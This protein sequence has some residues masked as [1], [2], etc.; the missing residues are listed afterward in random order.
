[1]GRYRWRNWYVGGFVLS[2][3]SDRIPGHNIEVMDRYFPVS[4][5]DAIYL[6]DL[7]EPLLD[8]ARRRFEKKGWRNVHV[9]CQDA[10]HFQL[11]G[12]SNGMQLEGS[13]GFV[14][15]SYSLSMVCTPLDNFRLG[16]HACFP[17]GRF[18]LCSRSC[19]PSTLPHRRS[20]GSRRLLH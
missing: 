1:M 18:S 3:V 10:Q 14:T 8:V 9:L 6:I 7:C 4:S 20:C 2:V 16:A 12:W 19:S 5:F 15:L 17:D 13:V 11:P